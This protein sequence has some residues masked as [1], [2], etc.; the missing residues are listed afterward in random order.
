M[1]LVHLR[2]IVG[3]LVPSSVLHP[4]PPIVTCGARRHGQSRTQVRRLP[5][6]LGTWLV[7]HE[8]ANTNGTVCAFVQLANLPVHKAPG[9]VQDL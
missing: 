3:A 5:S 6:R 9:S 1:S 7:E 2:A 8:D 4:G